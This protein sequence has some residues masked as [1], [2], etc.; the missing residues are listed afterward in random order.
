MRPASRGGASGKFLGCWCDLRRRRDA[1]LLCDVGSD[2]ST[3]IS[4][5][6]A[7]SYEMRANPEH[8]P[9][10]ETRDR[11]AQ[12]LCDLFDREQRIDYCRRSSCLWLDVMAF[13]MPA[14]LGVDTL[15]G[16]VKSDNP[17]SHF[18]DGVA[19]DHWRHPQETKCLQE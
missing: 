11:A 16:P 12:K 7:D 9:F 6:L 3:V 13:V 1:C 10:V 4:H 15:A 19:F 18:C 8:P 17:L 14:C 2:S 5:A